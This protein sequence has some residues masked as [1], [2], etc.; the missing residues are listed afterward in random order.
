MQQHEGFWVNLLIETRLKEKD[1]M[2]RTFSR[3]RKAETCT[4]PMWVTLAMSPLGNLTEIWT[5]KVMVLKKEM[6]W[7]MRSVAPLSRIQ[8]VGLRWEISTV[9]ENTEYSKEGKDQIPESSWPWSPMEGYAMI[10]T[11]W[12]VS[13]IAFGG[14]WVP[15]WH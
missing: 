7:T 13:T 6:E 2:Q 14:A 8:S 3:I 1:G 15:N 12:G 11:T 9:E 5:V 4:V 10:L